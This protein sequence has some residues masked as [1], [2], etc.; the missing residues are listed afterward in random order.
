MTKEIIKEQL[1]PEAKDSM[2][3]PAGQ[4]H[5]TIHVRDGG[6][7]PFPSF[8]AMDKNKLKENVTERRKKEQQSKLKWNWSNQILIAPPPDK[9]L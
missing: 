8:K 7:K 4:S 5:K 9:K 1:S 3:N 6:G 2:R